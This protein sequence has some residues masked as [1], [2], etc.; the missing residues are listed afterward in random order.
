MA[1]HPPRQ[2]IFLREWRKHRL[3]TQDQLADRIGVDRSYV[4]T[5]ERGKRPYNQEFLEAAAYALGIEP[6]DLLVR[7]PLDPTGYWTIWDGIP[8]EDRPRFATAIEALKQ[9]FK[10]AS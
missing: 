2:R 7:N 9:T 3:L 4:S 5:I 8:P 6:A 10:K 1:I